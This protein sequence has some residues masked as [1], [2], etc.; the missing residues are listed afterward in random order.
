[1]AVD[2]EIEVG[3][4]ACL[5]AQQR[6]D[7]PTSVQPYDQITAFK[8]AHN[9][10]HTRTGHKAER[11]HAVRK[12]C[13][14]PHPVGLRRRLDRCRVIRP[15]HP[16]DG[17]GCRHAGENGHAGEAPSRCDRSRPHSRLRRAHLASPERTLLRSDRPLCRD[18][19]EVRSRA[20]RSS[21]PA[22]RAST[23][24]PC[25]AR[26]TASDRALCDPRST[27]HESPCRRGA[28]RR[29]QDQR[30]QCAPGEGRFSQHQQEDTVS[31]RVAALS[32]RFDRRSP[33]SR[34]GGCG[35]ADRW[36]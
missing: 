2:D 10:D 16:G 29:S 4:C 17:L 7:P 28:S 35:V 3:M 36:W 15:A 24:D 21:P 30:R 11:S 27:T 26:K 13:E 18:R 20:S 19:L 12:G 25:R 23:D 33:G 22:T 8:L 6:V 5:A 14:P 1:M 31:A 32:S 9:L 34:L